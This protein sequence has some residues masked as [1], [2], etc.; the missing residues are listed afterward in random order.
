MLTGIFFASV[1]SFPH[2]N[3]YYTRTGCLFNIR[4]WVRS[5]CVC[6]CE[7]GSE[8]PADIETGPKGIVHVFSSL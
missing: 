4:K 2:N 1:T 8:M 7:R 5:V 3:Y 6:V